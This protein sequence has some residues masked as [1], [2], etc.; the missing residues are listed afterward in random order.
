LSS[1]R[2]ANH[3]RVQPAGNSAG[4]PLNRA[5]ERHGVTASTSPACAG[6]SARIVPRATAGRPAGGGPGWSGGAALRSGAGAPGA[7]HPWTLRP[8]Q[9]HQ[10]AQQ[11][12]R[13]QVAD[14][15]DHPAMIPT[16]ED[17]PGKARSKNRALQVSPAR[18]GAGGPASGRRR[19]R[20][21]GGWPGS[22]RT[23]NPGD[24]ALSPGQGNG[25]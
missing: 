25:R 21:T 13:D 20:S 4:Q 15:E 6:G 1:T 9:H 10:T 8:G 2:P 22:V 24:P 16:P 7:R 12:A 23:D 5:F 18:R 14:R 19:A 11:T 17:W 3:H